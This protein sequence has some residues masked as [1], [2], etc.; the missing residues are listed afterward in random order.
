MDN[1]VITNRAADNIRILTA[2]MVEKYNLHHIYKR[3]QG[4][5]SAGRGR[6]S[7]NFRMDDEHFGP[8]QETEGQGKFRPG[9][10]RHRLPA[11][12]IHG[13]VEP[14]CYIRDI[15]ALRILRDRPAGQFGLESGSNHHLRQRRVGPVL[16]RRHMDAEPFQKEV[17][18]AHYIVDK[19]PDRS[20]NSDYRTGLA[21]RGAVQDIV[22]GRTAVLGLN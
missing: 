15:R 22:H 7:H 21:G 8:V 12:G 9:C 17:Q 19:P 4:T 1:N 14:G 5:D 2:A 11:G 18:A 3:A 16:V 6:G 13:S 20:H 10:I